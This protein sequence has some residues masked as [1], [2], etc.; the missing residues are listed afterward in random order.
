MIVDPRVGFGAADR[1][2]SVPI[3]RSREPVVP[4]D[5]P[6]GFPC[7]ST[8]Y[9]CPT[10]GDGGDHVARA[11]PD[12]LGGRPR[13][14]G[15]DLDAHGVGEREARPRLRGERR[16]LR[17]EIRAARQVVRR[18]GRCRDDDRDRLQNPGEGRA[19]PPSCGVRHVLSF[20]SGS[21]RSGGPAPPRPFPIPARSAVRA[22]ARRGS[23]LRA[24]APPRRR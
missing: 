13:E 7:S 3:P 20:T 24:R 14:R 12:L 5:T 18:A 16:D 6:V 17:A 15:L 11:Q 1:R 10:A 23:T 2:T 22:L 19:G 9:R 4:A 21:R 8:T